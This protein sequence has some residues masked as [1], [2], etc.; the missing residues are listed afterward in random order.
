MGQVV[1]ET[2]R[3]HRITATSQVSA[4]SGSLL[5]FYVSRAGGT[6]SLTDGSGAVLSGDMVPDAGF[7]AFPAECRDGVSATI[8]GAL[9]VTLFYR[10]SR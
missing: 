6:I 3:A 7:H 5:G 10:A 1:V 8:T 4:E 2:A 9:D